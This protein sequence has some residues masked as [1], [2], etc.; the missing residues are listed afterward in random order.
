MKPR[1]AAAVLVVLVT[2]A[3]G[4]HLPE[5]EHQAAALQSVRAVIGTPAPAG[6]QT[7][8][9]GD[10]GPATVAN[11][12][13][14]TTAATDG[15]SGA[16][17]AVSAPSTS[18]AGAAVGSVGRAGSGSGSVGPTAGPSRAAAAGSP[19]A[20]GTKGSSSPGGPVAPGGGGAGQ[21]TPPSAPVAPAGGKAEIR[22]GSIG[23]ESGPGGGIF[24]GG[25]HGAKAWVADVN[26]RGGLNGHP[27][28]LI[29]V[30][31]GGD[32][33]R[34]FAGAKRLVESD[35]V[36]SFFATR[37]LFTE[38]AYAPY[39]EERHV[40]IVSTCG[41]NPVD[42][43]S[44]MTFDG[45]INPNAGGVWM[46]MGPILTETDKRKIALFYCREAPICQIV[47][48][49]IVKAQK[50]LGYTVAFEAQVSIAQPDYTAE[51]IA[52]R[53]AGSDAVASVMD[54]ASTLRIARSMSRQG[55]SA[56]YS[57]QFSNHD[58]RVLKNGGRDVEG[59]LISGA[60][61]PWSSSPLMADYRAA[62]DRYV[63]GGVKSDFGAGAW[64]GGKLMELI[65]ARFGDTVT[66]D[67]FLQGLYGLK[68]ETLG[69]RIAPTTFAQGSHDRTNLCMVPIV[70]KNG[71]FVAPHGDKFF[72]A[73]GWKPGG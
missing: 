12:T 35:K 28:R 16:A 3:C 18:G 4:S 53:N 33:S 5:R 43:P 47:R 69:G 64:V 44:P 31:D 60:T 66:S 29:T 56:P 46:H 54:N 42:G 15:P 55:W 67:D 59:F 41:C 20:A 62:I 19:G 63:S 34:A 8:A 48:D 40:P 25:L 36:Q 27:V 45:Y 21:V 22:L 39:L 26:A 10:G 6:S 7:V 2:G 61:A 24:L 49:N 1:V 68:E 38:Q 32:P 51:I 23:T 50:E 37:S 57:S 73:P 58:E 11:G 71:A 52:A 72:C 30:D 13:G 14:S 70:V 17:G 9:G 65:A